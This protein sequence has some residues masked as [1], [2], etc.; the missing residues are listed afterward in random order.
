MLALVY[1]GLFTLDDN[2]QPVGKLAKYWEFANSGKRLDITLQSGVTFHNGEPLTARDVCATL[3]RIKELSGMNDDQETDIAPEERGLYQSVM[4]YISGWSA[5]EEDD[6]QLSI[7]LRRSYYGALY[8]LT[9]PILPASEVDQA[10]PAGTGP[11]RSPS[12]SRAC[13]YG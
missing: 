8:A 6:L 13:S 2:E 1:E 11:Y 4:Y 3:D 7:S 5:S 12:T 9:F 10:A